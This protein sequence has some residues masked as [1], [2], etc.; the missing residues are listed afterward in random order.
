MHATTAH[1][2]G[3]L[4]ALLGLPPEWSIAGAEVDPIGGT[5]R[6][7]LQPASREAKLHAASGSLVRPNMHRR[8][9]KPN[10]GGESEHEL[11]RFIAWPDLG[12]SSTAPEWP[13]E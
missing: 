11:W 8:F 3:E 7:R 5:V 4:A 13:S 12:Q 10:A 1:T 9:T 2:Y 6:F